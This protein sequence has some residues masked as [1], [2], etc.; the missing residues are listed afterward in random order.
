MTLSTVTHT[1]NPPLT[2]QEKIALWFCAFLMLA[3]FIGMLFEDYPTIASVFAHCTPT[4]GM[5][6]YLSDDNSVTASLSIIVGVFGIFIAFVGFLLLFLSKF[7]N[8]YGLLF[9][10]ALTM[11]YLIFKICIFTFGKFYNNWDHTFAQ[12]LEYIFRVFVSLWW[13]LMC[14]KSALLLSGDNWYGN[15][16]NSRPVDEVF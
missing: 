11:I 1:A 10:L 7:K 14:V 12:N 9:L 4:G 16:K 15:R 2:T 8:V 5:F 13:L 3:P 6:T